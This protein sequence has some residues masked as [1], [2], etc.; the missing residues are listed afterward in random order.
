MVILLINRILICYN[1]VWHNVN[2]QSIIIK[3]EGECQ[4]WEQEDHANQ[5]S[6]ITLKMKWESIKQSS[7]IF[8]IAFL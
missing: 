8:E 1:K 4:E 6:P 5:F 2:N 3:E 7:I